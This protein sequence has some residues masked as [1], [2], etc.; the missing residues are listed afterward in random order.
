MDS[1]GGTNPGAR[2]FH[3]DATNFAPLDYEQYRTDLDALVGKWTFGVGMDIFQ[4][5]PE[6]HSW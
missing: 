5:M 1:H 3:L 4:K 2:L 6:W